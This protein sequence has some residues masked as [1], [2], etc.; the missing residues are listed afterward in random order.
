MLAGVH[1]AMCAFYSASWCFGPHVNVN[2]FAHEKPWSVDV[3]SCSPTQPAT[4]VPFPP[5]F[6]IAMS[7]YIYIYVPDFAFDQL[8]GAL[9]G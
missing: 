2:R 1:I 6:Q 4:Q 8:S 5:P 7:L 3:M 9:P